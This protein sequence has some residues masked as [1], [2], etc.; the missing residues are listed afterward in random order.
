MGLLKFSCGKQLSATE[1]LKIEPFAFNYNY[2]RSILGNI[3]IHFSNKLLLE[4]T[5]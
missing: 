3:L 1:Q 2:S 4:Y 5:N